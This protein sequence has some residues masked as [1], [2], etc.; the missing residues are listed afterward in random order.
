MRNTFTLLICLLFFVASAQ[1]QSK[2]DLRSRV[3]LQSGKIKAKTLGLLVEGIPEKVE[4]ACKQYDGWLKYSVGN[5]NSVEIPTSKI[6]EFSKEEAVLRIESFA[7]IGHKLIDTARINNNIDS[8]HAGYSPLTQSYSGKGV[9]VGIIDGGI[10]WQHPDFKNPD[11]ST[12]I[13]FIWD[14]IIAAPTNTPAP[15]NYGQEWNWIDIN[16]NKCTHTPA[17]SDFAHGTC[18]AGIASGNGRGFVSDTLRYRGIAYESDIIAVRIPT[19]SNNFLARVADAVDY[20]FKKADALG[21]PCVVNTSVGTYEGSRDGKDLTARII[22]SLVEQRKGRAVVAAGGNAG[23]I[24]YHVQHTITNDS[25]TT[26]FRYNKNVPGLYFDFW[27][28]SVQFNNA[29]FVIGAVSTKTG[30]LVD[31]VATERFNV[32]RDFNPAQ[33]GVTLTRNLYTDNG[34]QLLGTVKMYAEMLQ[35]I[36]HVEVLITPT[37]TSLWWKLQTFGTGSCDVWSSSSLIGGSDMVSVLPNLI[38]KPDY[39]YPDTLKTIVSSWQCSDKVITVA[40]YTNRAFYLDVDSISRDALYGKSIVG[41]RDISSSIGPTRDHR[42]K[43]DISATGSTTITTGDLNLIPQYL[44]TPGNRLK[45]GWGG[46]HMRNGGTSM[47]SPLVAGFA[48]LYFEKHPTARWD[49]VKE[50]IILTAKRDTFT[51]AVE[52]PYYG[53]GKLNGFRA[54]AHEF[55]YGCTDTGSLNYNP[56][57]NLDTGGCVKKVYGCTD[58]LATNYSPFANVNN[59]SCAYDTGTSA[60]KPIKKWNTNVRAFPNPFTNETVFAIDGLP[61]NFTSAEIVVN[62]IIGRTIERINIEKGIYQY[63]FSASGMASGVML[64]KLVI[65][66]KTLFTGKV[67][68]Q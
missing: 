45:I 54:L 2:I 25:A 18:V 20:I 31:T 58:T 44:S 62:D 6:I 42:L 16:T 48:A 68:K 36:Y 3:L 40:N 46:K 14:Q 66:H 12:R 29:E 65:D 47:A 38:T 9:V 35:D 50:A 67:V 34:I 7:A 4:A 15:Y 61:A 57:A 43:P 63:K 5:I 64:Y 39:R 49:E 22:D 59:G 17:A 41:M 32:L 10:Y 8:I 28:D 56:T 52:N 13:R 26:Y 24:P 19:S 55:I 23:N 21:K 11:G 33:G 60:I 37:D 30:N 51:T 1:E 53:N 27:A